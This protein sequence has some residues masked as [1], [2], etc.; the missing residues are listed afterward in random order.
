MANQY[1]KAY[2]SHG[3]IRGL[4]GLVAFAIVVGAAGSVVHTVTHKV[5]QGSSA[6]APATIPGTAAAP[7][8]TTPTTTTAPTTPPPPPAT[9]SLIQEP[10]AGFGPIY[11]FISSANKSLDMTMYELSDPQAQS[12]LIAD[13]KRGVT[14]RVLL[15]KDFTG[16][17]INQAA[18]SQLQSSG[19]QVRWALPGVIFH[20]KTI[21]VNATISAVG[22]ANLTSQYY[23][24][25]RD[26]WIMDSNSSD[27][28]AIEQTFDADWSGAAG[29]PAGAAGADLVWSPG[30]ES[31][32]VAEISSAQHSVSFESEELKTPA[33]VNAL[34][35]DAKRG[36]SCD[37][38]MTN[39][40]SWDAG[41]K[42]VTAAGCRVHAY[43][44]SAHALYIHEKIVLV[45][46]GTPQGKLLIGS[47][48]ASTASLQYNRE[49][50]VSL[51]AATAPAVINAVT[52]AFISDFNG[53]PE[54]TS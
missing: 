19:V 42:A 3:F 38:V 22:T 28:S 2:P 24:T 41:F 51:T 16:G 7:T 21:T 39:S 8:A 45:D 53:A 9:Y 47:Q 20:Q 27:V 26:A 54:W 34:A 18:F 32:M 5:G 13:A 4:V 11:S 49:L 44:A 17:Q 36:V 35:A 12:A 43:P 33:V 37:I 14:V 6:E 25:S 48:N 40:S 46:G 31:A 15:D 1:T 10:S 50:S 52:L 29:P 23:A 30:A